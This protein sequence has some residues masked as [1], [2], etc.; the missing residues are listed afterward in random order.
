MR[1]APTSTR[2]GGTLLLGGQRI[3]P[4][5]PWYMGRDG[6]MEI[7]S[8]AVVLQ[9]G[10]DRAGLHDLCDRRREAGEGVMLSLTLEMGSWT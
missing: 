4:P 7:E 3:S 8:A 6:E 5:L 1:N 10:A 9:G 2:A